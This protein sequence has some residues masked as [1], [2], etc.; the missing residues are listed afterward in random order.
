MAVFKMKNRIQNYAWGSTTAIPE[1]L[2]FENDEKK[3]MAELWM[4]AH[5]KAPS[6]AVGSDGDETGLDRL[7]SESPVDFLGPEAA[8]RFEGRLPYLFKV[9][10]AGTPLSIQAHPNRE[11]ARAGF[12][13]EN[14]AGIALDAFERN[15]KDDNH[16][17]EI[18]CA[19]SE[20]HAMRGFRPIAEIVSNFRKIAIPDIEEAV[21]L[22]EADSDIKTA[23]QTFFT[24]LMKLSDA[25]RLKLIS[26]ALTLCNDND[27]KLPGSRWIRRLSELYPGDIGIVSPLYLNVVTLQPGE[28]MY[29]PAG[30]LH[31]YLEGSG[32]ELMAN[33]DNVLRGGLTPKHVDVSELLATL[34]FR[35]G[36]PEILRPEK[37]SEYESA[38]K[39]EAREFY[40]SRIELNGNSYSI[41][42]QVYG[43]G[44]PSILICLEGCID[45]TDGNRIVSMKRGETVFVSFGSRPTL[46]GTGILFR[47]SVPE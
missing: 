8:E 36:K 14:D 18:I 17:P 5:P 7:I 23:L 41:P 6:I 16:K 9:L 2:G 35:P 31:A 30:V 29:L 33:S 44:F 47:A 12:N 40:L 13:R 27:V 38:Y 45:I 1:L 24:M 25:S 10:A 28:A 32:I 20:Y 39:T 43:P 11:Q 34:D 4:G 3:T 26:N 37:I 15:Y 46:N 22:L 19:L 21:A 42:K